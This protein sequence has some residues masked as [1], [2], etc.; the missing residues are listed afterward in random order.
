LAVAIRDKKLKNRKDAKDAKK[1]KEEDTKKKLGWLLKKERI[2]I[3]Q[4]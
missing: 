1:E 3:I 2:M 4:I